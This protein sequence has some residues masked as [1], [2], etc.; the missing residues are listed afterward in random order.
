MNSKALCLVQKFNVLLQIYVY[1]KLSSQCLLTISFY[2]P[3][4]SDLLLLLY[5]YLPSQQTPPAADAKS[6]VRHS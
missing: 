3:A 2:F 6:S 1:Y 4:F 5:F